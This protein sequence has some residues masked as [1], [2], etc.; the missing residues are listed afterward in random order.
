MK[1]MI[2]FVML[3][4]SLNVYSTLPSKSYSE[5]DHLPKAWTKISKD[6][7]E[8]YNEIGQKTANELNIKFQPYDTGY[9]L[10]KNSN[11]KTLIHPYLLLSQS[12]YNS[13]VDF[14][15][16][17]SMFTKDI[18][19]VNDISSY[20][21]RDLLKYSGTNKIISDKSRKTIFWFNEYDLQEQGGVVDSITIYI[22]RGNTVT[23]L[24]FYYKPRQ[25]EEY[26]VDLNQFINYYSTDSSLSNLKTKNA[27]TFNFVLF[28]Q[29]IFTGALG[30][31]IFSI[32]CLLVNRNKTK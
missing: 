32:V 14:N 11:A 4:I 7:I 15:T 29:M 24:M 22:L 6:N 26:L 28:F 19:D 25:L 9:M 31:I 12:V 3:F 5:V 20:G 8:L 16:L 30:G 10:V 1:R 18:D 23:N 17:I 21:I 2:Y 13:E 27:A